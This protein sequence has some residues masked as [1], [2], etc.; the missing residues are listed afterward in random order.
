MT[1]VAEQ[2]SL[3]RG[4]TPRKLARAV[5]FEPTTNR[6]TADCSTAELRPKSPLSSGRQEGAYSVLGSPGQ[7]RK[8]LG[9]GSLHLNRTGGG[10][11]VQEAARHAA[12]SLALGGGR[13]VA[14][15]DN[16]GVDPGVIKR[17]PASHRNRDIKSKIP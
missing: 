7:Q 10:S 15:A 4:G 13:T 9:S 2:V 12:A 8:R 14:V 6:L 17:H 3:Q 11:A 5:G 1:Q 16:I